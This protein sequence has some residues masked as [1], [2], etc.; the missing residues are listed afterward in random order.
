MK[1]RLTLLAT[2]CI[3]AFSTASADSG[4]ALDNE[5]YPLDYWALR[6]VINNAQVSPN[7]K[8]LGIMKIPAKDANPIIEVYE[9]ADLSKEPFRLNADPMEITSFYWAGPEHII[10]TLR[11]QVRDTIDGFNQGVYETKVA[12]LNVKKQKIRSFEET[13]P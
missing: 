13:G 6:P 7:G 8:Y 1:K 5:P 4:V 10:F 12:S 9:T 2:L 3:A 11:Q